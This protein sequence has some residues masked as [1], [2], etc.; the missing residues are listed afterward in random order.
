MTRNDLERLVKDG[1]IVSLGVPVN[2]ESKAREILLSTSQAKLKAAVDRLAILQPVLD[3]HR[4]AKSLD[5]LPNGKEWL[6][7]ARKADI[8]YSN[9]LIGCI[10]FSDRQGWRGSHISETSEALIT[11]IIRKSFVSTLA[12]KKAAAYGEYRRV[13]KE[14]GRAPVHSNY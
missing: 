6:R 11:E 13:C 1:G 7:R 4:P 14:R 8:Q 10:D 12:S 9:P 2:A 3:G 5:Q